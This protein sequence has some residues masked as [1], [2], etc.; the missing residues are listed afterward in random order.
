MKSDYKVAK[1][2]HLGFPTLQQIRARK[3]KTPLK[4]PDR[5]AQ[6]DECM[7]LIKEAR[8]TKIR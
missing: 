2:T 1:G 7:R 6:I 8:N 3:K 5:C 4:S